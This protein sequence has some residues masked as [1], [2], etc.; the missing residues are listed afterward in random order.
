MKRRTR[1]LLVC[2]ETL[3]TIAATELGPAVGGANAGG[4]THGEPCTLLPA[5]VKDQTG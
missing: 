3:R 1:K 5:V 2:R 4:D